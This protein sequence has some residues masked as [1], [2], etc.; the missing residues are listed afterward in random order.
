MSLPMSEWNSD[1]IH[2][3]GWSGPPW[4]GNPIKAMRMTCSSPRLTPNWTGRSSGALVRT[5]S[6][7]GDRGSDC[8]V[9]A[10][11]WPVRGQAGLPQKGN[12]LAVPHRVG[13]TF[14]PALVAPKARLVCR[15]RER[16]Q[17]LVEVGSITSVSQRMAEL[18]SCRLAIDGASPS[19]LKN[20]L[21]QFRAVGVGKDPTPRHEVVHVT[22]RCRDGHCDN[23]IHSTTLSYGRRTH[24]P[25][26]RPRMAEV[27]C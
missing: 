23:I 2:S 22:R 7:S 17:G 26:G 27:G 9:T 19:G 10:A 16:Q 6:T 15:P 14:P 4:P 24:N 11:V 13:R 5:G 21:L 1:A 20:H 18:C 12:L 3:G 25:A 8:S